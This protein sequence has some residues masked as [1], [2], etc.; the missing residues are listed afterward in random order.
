MT[1][2]KISSSQLLPSAV[3]LLFLSFAINTCTAKEQC[4]AQ[5]LCDLLG[6]YTADD[7]AVAR[8]WRPNS[9]WFDSNKP[10]LD[11]MFPNCQNESYC[12]DLFALSDT[13]EVGEMLWK[14]QNPP[15]CSTAKLAVLEDTWPS[16]MGSALHV[17]G[18]ALAYYVL[19][20]GRALVTN[21]AWSIYSNANDCPGDKTF[22][23]YFLPVSKCKPPPSLHGVPDISSDPSPRVVKTSTRIYPKCNGFTLKFAADN[24]LSKFN[25][26]PWQWWYPQFMAYILR[27]Q[28]WMLNKFV[29]PLQHA[30]FFKTG[31]V[32]PHPIAAIFVRRGDKSK[33]VTLHS[34]EEY[35][36]QFEPVATKLNIKHVYISSDDFT[37]IEGAIKTY[38]DK[39]TFHFIDYH[40]LGG[41]L[42]FDHVTAMR[43]MIMSRHVRMSL[44]DLYITAQ[45]DVMVGTQSSNWCRLHDGELFF[46]IKCAM[47]VCVCV[48]VF[49]STIGKIRGGSKKEEE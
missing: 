33:E 1:M 18:M 5:G 15:D 14:L 7:E 6:T 4:D 29:W 26:K 34:Y 9:S 25:D 11:S 46:K 30:A 28:P 39:Y 22:S 37:Q 23:C 47:C 35:F 27:P 48:F 32:I 10:M 41:G 49:F 31:G 24:P 43:G 42:S 20:Q 13:R 36:Q 44:A 40:R 3:L 19:E 38:G 21:A 2:T 8:H 16:G 17:Y 12:D 45:A